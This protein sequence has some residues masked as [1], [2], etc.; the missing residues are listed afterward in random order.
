MHV[1]PLVRSLLWTAGVFAIFLIPA[2][3]MTA[4]AQLELWSGGL[5]VAC[6]WG[7]WRWG[8]TAWR[9]YKEGSTNPWHYGVL[10]IVILLLFLIVQR[11]YG[12]VY[13]RAGRPVEWQAFPATAFIVFGIMVAVWLFSLATK[14][15]GEKPSR[16]MGVITAVGA[17]LALFA[18]SVWPVL[19]SKGGAIIKFFHTLFP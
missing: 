14:V 12:V 18:S 17:A 19:A 1:S 9:A 2:S 5:T 10:A 8:P 7:V 13:I 3:F 15:D 4:D 11:V 6:L 16:L